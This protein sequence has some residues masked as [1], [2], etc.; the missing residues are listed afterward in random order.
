[1]AHGFDARLPD[2]PTL[3]RR[4]LY[5]GCSPAIEVLISMLFISRCPDENI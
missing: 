1:M 4:F 3:P 5:A 2:A